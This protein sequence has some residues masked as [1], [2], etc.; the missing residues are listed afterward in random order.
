MLRVSGVIEL[1]V[2]IYVSTRRQ[3]PGKEILDR[4]D[5]SEISAIVRLPATSK[6]PPTIRCFF[7]Q[8]DLI[9]ASGNRTSFPAAVAAVQENDQCAGSPVR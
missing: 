9:A 1:I 4:A 3:L 6:T 2:L 7:E 5:V 8:H